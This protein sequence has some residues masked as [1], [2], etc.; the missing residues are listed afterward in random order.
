M[1]ESCC[2]NAS[3]LLFGR[4]TY[5]HITAHWPTA[6]ADEIA[7]KMNHL[8]KLAFS[9]TLDKVEWNNSTPV[10]GDYAEEVLKLKQP[11]G[12]GDLVILGSA[13]LA[14]HSLQYGLV[15]EYRVILNP[16]RLGEGKPLFPDI[17][18][19]INLKLTHTKPLASGVILLHYER[20]EK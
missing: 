5:E 19:K 12:K 7:Y 1:P 8:P 16:V 14:S 2:A 10:K 13:M 9:G 11:D 15:D 18:K 4:N 20:T 17:Q 3:A 6:R